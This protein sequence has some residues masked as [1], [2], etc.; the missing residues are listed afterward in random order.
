MK[1]T[2]RGF[3]GA[4][5]SGLAGLVAGAELDPERALWVPG[6][7][8]HFDMGGGVRPYRFDVLYGWTTIKPE[9]ALRVESDGDVRMMEAVRSLGEEVDRAM[10]ETYRDVVEA[11]TEERVGLRFDP[12][13]FSMVSKSI[14]G[15]V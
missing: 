6:Q 4:M 14:W 12:R 5:A 15:E 13:A 8:V 10:L 1:P 2:R 9:L 3:I 7:R 11:I